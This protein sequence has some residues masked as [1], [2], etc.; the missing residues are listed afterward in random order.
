MYL[1]SG[2]QTGWGPENLY[3][4]LKSIQVA[5]SNC[6]QFLWIKTCK[7]KQCYSMPPL[8]LNAVN[9]QCAPDIMAL[10]GRRSR[11]QGEAWGE[12]MNALGCVRYGEYVVYAV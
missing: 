9:H 5:G 10:N 11:A 1:P 4:S 6:D 8:D 3:V 7:T 12:T 2:E